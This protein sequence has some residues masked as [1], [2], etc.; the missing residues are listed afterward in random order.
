MDDKK[1]KIVF[2][3]DKGSFDSPDHTGVN[4]KVYSQ[5]EQMKSR[6]ADVV[7]EKYEWKDRQLQ[8][9][10]DN[11][12]DVLYF[13]RMES[14]RKLL[15]K[16]EEFKQINP[17][18]RI[19]MEIPTYPFKG[20]SGKIPLKNK[21]NGFISD[22]FL[23][24]YI[25]KVVVCSPSVPLKKFHGIPV[26]EFRNGVDFDKLIINADIKSENIDMICVSGCTL[27]QG[28]DRIIKGLNDY[29][30][31]DGPKRTVNLHV[32]GTG[33][34]LDYYKELATEYN[35]IDKHVFFY[36]KRVGEELDTVYGKCNVALGHLAT[37]RI[38]ISISPALK[39]REY[40]ARGLPIVSATMLDIYNDDTKP[41]ILKISDDE[42]NVN[43]NEI[44][45]FVDNVYSIDDVHHIIRNTFEPFCD[46]KH[47][48][49]DVLNYIFEGD[50]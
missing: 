36:G 32:V 16:L 46:W 37:H 28:Y 50:K 25:D 45:D 1:M 39:I 34:Y 29:Y 43:V 21:V 7:L 10:V 31:S 22:F 15:K 27:S 18:I 26:I 47:V 3:V 41:Y 23:H 2:A 4:I 38:G 17:N 30:L 48:Y 44:V 8:L 6:G 11:D 42:T 5:I 24:R 19:V 40:G 12:I 14:S 9:N 20:E 49:V 33:E 35:L 13:R